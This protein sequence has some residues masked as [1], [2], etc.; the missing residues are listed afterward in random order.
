VEQVGE[1]PESCETQRERKEATGGTTGPS[2]HGGTYRE[3]VA[4]AAG[5]GARKMTLLCKKIAAKPDCNVAE[6]S[7]EGYGSKRGY[8]AGDFAI[9]LQLQNMPLQD[10]LKNDF[11]RIMADR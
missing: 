5:L 1:P 9:T 2:W 10:K 8:F 4:Q 7:Q 3:L 6:T 11:Q